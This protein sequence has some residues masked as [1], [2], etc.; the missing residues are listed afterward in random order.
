MKRLLL[1]AIGTAA[2]AIGYTAGSAGGSS[3]P[4][5]R[6]S[7]SQLTIRGGYEQARTFTC[8]PGF[9]ATSGYW[10]SS[11]VGLVS[12]YNTIDTSNHRRWTVG[13]YNLN[14]RKQQVEV[15]VVCIHG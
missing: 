2:I 3:G 15:G 4:R 5:I 14:N 8:P 6:Y 9:D 11:A 13:I 7:E 12:D 1:T 10:R